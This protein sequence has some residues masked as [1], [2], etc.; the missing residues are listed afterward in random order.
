MTEKYVD[1][2]RNHNNSANSVRRCNATERSGH[3]G[4]ECVK[5]ASVVASFGFNFS[6]KNVHSF[7]AGVS[8]TEQFV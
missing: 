7:I 2:F 8:M 3:W 4:T 6:T 1:L 5:V